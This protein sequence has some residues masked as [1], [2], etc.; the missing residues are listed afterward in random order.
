[1]N[2][3]TFT[4]TNDPPKR[5]PLRFDNDERRQTTLFAGLDCL[6]GQTDLFATDGE[7]QLPPKQER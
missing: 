1:M 5:A 7:L 6:E 2:D 3:D 4:L